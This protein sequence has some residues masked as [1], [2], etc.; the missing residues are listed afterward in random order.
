MSLKLRALASLSLAT[1]LLGCGPGNNQFA[2]ACP[3]PKLVP[4]LA[5]VTRF[6]SPGVAHDITDL[7]LTGRITAINVT[8]MPGEDKNTL[9]AKVV[10]GLN[11]VRGPSMQG[12]EADVPVF[13]AVTVGTDVRDKH[14][15]PVHVSFPPNVDRIPV[16]SPDI[17]LIVPVSS[18]ITGASYTVIAGFQLTPDELAANRG[19]R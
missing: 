16:V 5:D 15:Y 12:R 10:I 7:V 2:P 17:D 18:Q 11:I 3:V 13:L 4:A 1:L 6:N 14:V 8:C 19:A 9:A